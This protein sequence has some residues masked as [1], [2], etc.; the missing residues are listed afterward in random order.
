MYRHPRFSNTIHIDVAIGRNDN[1]GVVDT[2]FI[3]ES[4]DYLSTLK[5]EVVAEFVIATS[6]IYTKFHHTVRV[7][8][9]KLCQLL[10]LQLCDRL[11]VGS[12]RSEFHRG[13]RHRLVHR[14]QHGEGIPF[15]ALHCLGLGINDDSG[16]KE[17]PSIPQNGIR[18]ILVYS[19]GESAT[20]SRAVNYLRDR[21]KRH[22]GHTYTE[23]IQLQTKDINGIGFI[24]IGR[25]VHR[26]ET[27]AGEGTKVVIGREE[28][29]VFIGAKTE[30][31]LIVA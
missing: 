10:K 30:T 3:H 1:T 26:G 14:Y 23:Q 19:D 28:D 24:R 21:L 31:C 6:H 4:T 27:I 22:I 9:E 13:K 11:Q 2:F 17:K 16:N 18:F 25:I 12:R 7:V 5:G 20:R 29:T 8:A 15:E